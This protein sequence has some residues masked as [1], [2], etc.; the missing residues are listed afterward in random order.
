MKVRQVLLFV[1]VVIA[2][3]GIIMVVFPRE[4]IRISKDVVLYFPS[5]SDFFA[6]KQPEMDIDS[7]LSKQFDI[8]NLENDDSISALDIE[9]LKKLVTPLEFPAGNTTALDP[10]FAKLNS[11]DGDGKVRIMHYGDSQIEGDRITAFLRNKFQSRFGGKGMGLTTAGALYSQF[12]IIQNNSENWIRYQG[13]MGQQVGVRNKKYGAMISF[14]R[15]SPL[16]DSA[17]MPGTT[18]YKAWLNFRKSDLAYSNTKQFKTITIFYGNAKASTKI[19]ISSGDVVLTTD[20]LKSGEG[21]HVFTYSSSTYLENVK[22]EFEGCDS[23]DFY[24]ISFEDDK[25]VYIDNIALRGSAGTVFSTS[26]ATLLSQMYAKLDIDLFILQFGGNVMPYIKDA[27]AAKQHASYFYSQMAFL[28]RLVPDACF[29]VIGPSDMSV[30]EKD[31][32]I[33]YPMLE[34]VRDELKA[35]THKAGGVYWDMYKAMGGKNSMIAWVNASPPLAGTDFTHFT[36]Q[37]TSVIANMFYNALI[38]EYSSYNERMK[39]PQ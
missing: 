14:S 3:L 22:F 16:L 20:S 38:L 8:N 35:A 11:M 13:Y 25:G 39:K 24:A 28:K 1:L 9:E 2:M 7:M 34:T 21:L 26:D 18:N 27:K 31:Q 37:G 5:F 15:F 10:F 33:T 30:K 6:P 36:P 23:P 12:S 4:G 29:I 32:Y 17:A 19:S